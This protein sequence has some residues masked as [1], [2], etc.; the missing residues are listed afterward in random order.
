M[1]IV[2]LALL[3][4][5]EALVR[6]DVMDALSRLYIDRTTPIVT[7]FHKEANRIKEKR[8]RHGSCGMGMGEAVSDSLD[9]LVLRMY[10]IDSPQDAIRIL[11]TIQEKKREECKV[12]ADESDDMSILDDPTAPELCYDIYRFLSNRVH[13]VRNMLLWKDEQ[14]IFEGAGGILLD[15]NYGFHPHTMWSTTTTENISKLW[16]EE[17][18]TLGVIRTYSTRHGNGPFVTETDLPFVDKYN[19]PNEWQGHFRTGLFDLEATKYAIKVN[20]GVD[21]LVVT[22]TD[23]LCP[24]ICESYKDFELV[25]PTKGDLK[26]QS[27]VTEKLFNIDVNT[28]QLT[29]PFIEEIGSRLG[30]PVMIESFGARSCD[31]RLLG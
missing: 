26:Q 13:V 31:K 18:T 15:E 14:V 4:E 21:A 6:K 7:P 30:L 5:N 9:D 10:N 17:I 1:W 8:L 23:E 12:I 19:T 27:K 24:I 2:P 16:N 28:T 3:K 29:A 11:K 25:P 22:H 20:G